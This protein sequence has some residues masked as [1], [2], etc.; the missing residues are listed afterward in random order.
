MMSRIQPPRLLTTELLSALRIATHFTVI[1]IAAAWS[2]S[3]LAGDPMTYPVV[4]RTDL[5]EP[6]R[7]KGKWE[8]VVTQEPNPDELSQG[9]IHVCFVH[10]GK[11]NC[12]ANNLPPCDVI[13]AQP[14]CHVDRTQAGDVLHYN[15]FESVEIFDP[16][17]S[18]VGPLLV[19]YVGGNWGGPGTPLGPSVWRYNPEHDAFREIFVAMR[20][21]NTNGEARFVTGGPLAGSVITSDETIHRPYPYEI[22]VYRLQATGRYREALTYKGAT[23]YNDG[24]PLAVIDSEM[25]ET[26]RRL[27]LWRPGDALPTPGRVPDG[28]TTFVLRKG[29]EWCGP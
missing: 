12:A 21:S 2:S 19:L 3:A 27:G 7:T 29:E 22:T 11:P 16:K 25:P 8:V 14:R 1:A 24:N 26:L 5:T 15:I 4:S 13:D 17:Q 9:D 28:C 18:F 23:R 10:D 6:F 20:S